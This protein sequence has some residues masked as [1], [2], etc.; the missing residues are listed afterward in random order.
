M[1]HVPTWAK[2]WAIYDLRDFPAVAGPAEWNPQTSPHRLDMVKHSRRLRAPAII[3]D[4]LLGV[5]IQHHRS[6]FAGESLW[7]GSCAGQEKPATLCAF[8]VVL[9][10]SGSNAKHR[11]LGWH[12]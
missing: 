7:E 12:L 1:C 4:R 8:L 11:A 3:S 2:L 5:R 9:A 6:S 10:Q